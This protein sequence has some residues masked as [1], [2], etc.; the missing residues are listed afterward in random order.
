MAMM[1]NGDLKSAD[2]DIGRAKAGI[3]EQRRTIE[4]LEREN[5]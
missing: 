4:A 2:E 1:T 3:E 5:R